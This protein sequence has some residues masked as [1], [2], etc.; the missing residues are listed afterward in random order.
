M[1]YA[2]EET[3]SAAQHRRGKVF[4]YDAESIPREIGPHRE[5]KM[6]E[7]NEAVT[8]GGTFPFVIVMCRAER[9]AQK[10]RMLQRF[11][12]A[13]TAPNST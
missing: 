6:S 11:A 4:F 1:I 7:I 10:L 12:E 3:V 2:E 13:D 5:I 8:D 9:G